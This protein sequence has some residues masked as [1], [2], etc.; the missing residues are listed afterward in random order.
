MAEVDYDDP[1]PGCGVAIGDHTFRAY[2]ACLQKAGFDYKLPSETIPG[3]PVRFPNLDAIPCGNVTVRSAVLPTPLGPMPTLLWDFEGPGPKPM[4]RRHATGG[5][6]L[7][8]VMDPDTMRQLKEIVTRG[9][10]M[11][12]E[13]AEKTT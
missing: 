8:L 5:T 11:A 1:C 4:E 2:A 6:P 12:I 13:A 3:G 10:D 7:A 9:I